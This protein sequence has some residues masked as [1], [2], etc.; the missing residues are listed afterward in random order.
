VSVKLQFLGSGDA[1]GSG[2]RLQ[3]CLRLFG[4]GDDVLIDCGATSLVAMRRAGVDPSTIGWIVLTHLHGDHFGGLPFLI[5]D[6]Q[7]ARRTR[8]LV[9]AG[10]PTLEARVRAAME[11]FF[12]GSSQVERR[13]PVEF[14]ELAERNAATI[15]P[16]VVTAFPVVHP[17]GA[18]SYA[19]RVDYGGKV[20]TYSGDTE[21]TD[22]LVEAATDADL[23][24][25]EAYFFDKAMKFHLD[26]ARLLR[27]R[28]RL[29]CRRLV[30]AHMSRDMLDRRAEVEVEAAED[31]QVLA[32]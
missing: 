25:C 31:M 5:L 23:M 3:M 1:F 18:P 13:F 29:T 2:G 6:G 19:V 12:P 30:L 22:A 8:P 10:P 20:V 11:V 24:V 7:F 21:W 17:S 26:Y 14:V 27:E 16:A 32:L 9:V 15:G 28:A 4:A